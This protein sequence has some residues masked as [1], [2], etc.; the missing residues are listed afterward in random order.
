VVAISII[1]VIASVVAT[2]VVAVTKSLVPLA[3]VFLLQA[4]LAY[5]AWLAAE[6]FKMLYIAFRRNS[7]K[8]ARMLSLVAVGLAVVLPV[9]FALWIETLL[10]NPSLLLSW[11]IL[12]YF[13]GVVVAIIYAKAYMD[14]AVD[15]STQ[16]FDYAAVA[17]VVSAF[18]DPVQILALIAGVV[19][20]VLFFVAV[21]EARERLL[22]RMFASR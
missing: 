3:V 16:H 20:L 9:A 1:V 6:A 14:L 11:Q 17:L 13:I 10:R 8:W 15:T 5:P 2:T 18:L 19:A 21:N 22:S 4:L 12:D 7:Y